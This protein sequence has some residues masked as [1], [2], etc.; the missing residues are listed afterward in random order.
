MNQGRIILDTNIWVSYFI[1]AQLPKLVDIII[2]N[3]L[4]VYSSN[5]LIAELTEVMSR[6]KISKYLSLPVTEYIDFHCDLVTVI[7]VPLQF[8][9]CPD[10][11]DDYLFDLA[12]KTDALIVT[13]DKKLLAVSPLSGVN[14]MS[15]AAF[16]LSL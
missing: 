12:T 1:K 2:D 10:P 15:L 11:K 9:G 13:G 5:E 14:L 8:K 4:I 3:N 16:K 7:S 6:K